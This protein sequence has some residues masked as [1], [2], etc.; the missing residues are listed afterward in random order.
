M[1][2][3]NTT[4]M[5]AAYTLGMRPDGRE[6][7]VV[8][9]KGTFSFPEKKGDPAPLASEQV[10]LVMADEPSGEPGQSATLYESDFCPVKPRCDVLLNGQAYAPGGQPAERVTVALQAGNLQKAFDVVGHRSWKKGVLG[11]SATRPEPFL[12]MPITYDTAFGGSDNSHEKEKKH[13]AYA[14]NP[15]GVGFHS[16][17][18][19]EAIEDAPL[20]NTEEEGKPVHNPRGKYRPMAFGALGRGWPQRLQYGGTYDQ[21]W[22]DN[23]FPFLPSDFDERYYQAAPED[24]QLDQLNE[25]DEVILL[26]LTADGHAAFRLPKLEVPVTFF[27]TK[28]EEITTQ[29][30]ADT[31]LIEPDEKRFCI[32]WRVSL[33]LKKDIFEVAQVIVGRMPRSWYRARKLGKEWHPSLGA[34]VAAQHPEKEVP[35]PGEVGA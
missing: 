30:I 6:L 27:L 17:L 8:V 13:A 11:I 1:D 24:Q 7:L 4:K 26:N 16:N 29:A 2:L 10:D 28:G 23:V 3:L 18:A 35:E 20:P 15:V 21:N 31:L 5:K 25:G 14:D 34:W 33:P 19:V 32:T 9:V 12:T 22:V